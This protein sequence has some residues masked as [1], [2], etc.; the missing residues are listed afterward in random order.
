MNS[1]YLSTAYTL[2]DITN[3][4]E[5]SSISSEARNQQRNWESVVQVLG[6]RT[7]LMY[8]SPPEIVEVEL[9]QFKFGSSFTGKQRV[10]K[11]RFGVEFEAIYSNADRPYG[12]LE[13]DF[14]NVP[15]ITGLTETATLP[16][17][18][19]VVSGPDTNIYFESYSI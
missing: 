15:I 14:V 18:A 4:G 10:W 12:T 6:L 2:V 8:L 17:P 11:F 13:Q 9:S 1:L 7:Q 16:I 19:F 3:T 5:V